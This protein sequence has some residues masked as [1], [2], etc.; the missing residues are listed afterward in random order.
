MGSS[1]HIGSGDPVREAMTGVHGDGGIRS[2]GIINRFENKLINDC[3]RRSQIERIYTTRRSARIRS[4]S[5]L[6]CGYIWIE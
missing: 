6:E 4:R 3:E 5:D 2:S 1:I